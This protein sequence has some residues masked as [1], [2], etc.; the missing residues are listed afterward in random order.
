MRYNFSFDIVKHRK[1]FFT[2]SIVITLVGILT[3]A[4]FGLNYGVDFKAGTTLDIT[5]GGQAI[6]KAKVEQIVGEVG[7]EDIPIT[8]GGELNDR[9]TIR[10]DKVLT[11][12]QVNSIEAAFKTAYGDNISKE[13]NTVDTELAKELAIKAFYAVLAAS[14]GIIIYVSIR[15]EWRF[16]IAGIVALLHDAFIVISLFSILRLEVNLTFIAALL[17]IIGY[18]INDTIVI[19]DR[20]RE[21]LRFARIKTFDDL[22]DLVNKSIWQTM[23]RSINTMI[24]VLIAALCL[25]ILGSTAI[26]LF[27]LA[28]IFGLLSGAYSSIFIASTIWLLLKNKSLGSKKRPTAVTVK[29]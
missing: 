28:M 15:F 14:V 11:A 20:I 10:F 6:D 9:V 22:A 13:E 2:L 29:E 5:T 23:T 8:V 12:E 7:F 16:A 3:L 24:T 26:Q 25:Y 17:T 1:K 21:N 4:L 19:F 27:S 18:S